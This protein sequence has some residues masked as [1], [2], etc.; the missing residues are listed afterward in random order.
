LYPIKDPNCHPFV[1]AAIIDRKRIIAKSI[2]KESNGLY[3]FLIKLSK[4][5]KNAQLS[6]IWVVFPAIF[7]GALLV[8]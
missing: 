5:S 6:A 4:S 8:V 3:I 2:R 7:L 1:A